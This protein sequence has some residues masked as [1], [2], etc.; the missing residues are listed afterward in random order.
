MPPLEKGFSLFARLIDFFLFYLPSAGHVC[1]CVKKHMG[2]GI[3]K[4]MHS[5]G[6]GGGHGVCSLVKFAVH[7]LEHREPF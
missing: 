7:L 2:K 1:D 4:L 6:E 5:A 3:E